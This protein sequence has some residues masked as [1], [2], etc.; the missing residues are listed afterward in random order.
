MKRIIFA[1]LVFM[2]LPLIS[3]SAGYVL[4][5]YGNGGEVSNPS[6]G[7]E[8]GGIFLS[9]YHPRGGAFSLGI[10]ASIA[11]TEED[12]PSISSGDLK[13]NDGNEQEIYASFGAEIVPAFFGVVGLGY[14]T[15]KINSI[16]SSGN[17][18]TENDNNFA[19]MIGM[20]YAVQWIDM[21]LG[22]DNRRGIVAG[23]GL[24]F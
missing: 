5:T 22:Y 9:P 11:D 8:L 7:M 6:Y 2:V 23:I 12:Q 18:G 15:Q 13:A 24:A 10:G 16:N 1:A 14:S 20:R 17:T 19:W 21:S 3:H 4:A